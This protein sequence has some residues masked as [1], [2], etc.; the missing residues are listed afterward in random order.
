[1][2]VKI[3]LLVEGMDNLLFNNVKI[4]LILNGPYKI[5]AYPEREMSWEK[6]TALKQNDLSIEF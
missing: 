2:W 5:I 6:W 1:M 3:S 4:G